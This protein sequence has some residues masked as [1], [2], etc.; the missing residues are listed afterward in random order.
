MHLAPMAAGSGAGLSTHRPPK[1]DREP[2]AL[3]PSPAGTGAGTGTEHEAWSWSNLANSPAVF[4]GVD[5]RPGYDPSQD[6]SYW[7][8]HQQAGLC[9][10]FLDTRA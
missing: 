4:A 2:Q 1:A 9:V 3:A 5:A 8:R 7:H 10:A 6:R